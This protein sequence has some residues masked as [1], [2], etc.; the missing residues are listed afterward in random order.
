MNGS[1]EKQTHVNLD[2]KEA[3]PP[4]DRMASPLILLSRGDMV[5]LLGSSLAA[6]GLFEGGGGG[7]LREKDGAFVCVS[8]TGIGTLLL[9]WKAVGGR[10]DGVRLPL[11]GGIG[12]E[13]P[14]PFKSGEE[15]EAR[16]LGTFSASA[17]PETIRLGSRKWFCLR[18]ALEEARIR[19]GALKPAGDVVRGGGG[20]DAAAICSNLERSELTGGGGEDGSR[21]VIVHEKEE[22]RRGN[23]VCFYSVQ[24]MTSDLLGTAASSPRRPER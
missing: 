12:L 1:K 4:R 17:G 22:T 21:E 16:R 23:A 20:D 5:L 18:S 2:L 13:L 11:G 19:F 24:G 3:T 9:S 15:G 7:G 8:C 6:A 10:G 14:M